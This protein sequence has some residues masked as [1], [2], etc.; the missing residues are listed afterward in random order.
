M[1]FSS[2]RLTATL[3][4]CL[5]LVAGT[6]LASPPLRSFSSRY[7]VS[8]GGLPMGVMTR[9]L[10]LA[11]DGGYRFTSHFATS[12]LAAALKPLA[13]D[14]SSRGVVDEGR[15]VP[16]EYRYTRSSGRKKKETSTKFEWSSLQAIGN[17][18]GR[19]WQVTLKGGELDQ[20]VYQLALAGDLSSKVTELRYS[21]PEGGKLQDY[22]LTQRGTETIESGGK[23]ISTLRVE[24]LRKDKR[25]TTLWC[26]PAQDFLPVQIEY[27]EKDGS[28]SV[29][30]LSAT[31]AQDAD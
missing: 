13:I 29:A 24:Y 15:F 5:W 9:E 11:T 12:G 3:A 14:E 22:P 16:H 20:L 19:D 17:T 31:L 21:V 25:R 1:R 27:R 2:Q 8:A 10:K 18:D 26:D 28:L 6:S 30:R 4:L 7:T 23:S